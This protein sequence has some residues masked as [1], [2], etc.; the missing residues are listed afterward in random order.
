MTSTTMTNGTLLGILIGLAAVAIVIGA[1]IATR[2][3]ARERSIELR[4]QFGPEY[5]QAVEDY[6]SQT[7]AEREL[8]ARAR[9]VG[10][11]KLAELTVAARERYSVR[12]SR[13][14]EQFV[15]DPLAAV[16]AASSLIDDVMRARGYPLEDFD[17]R[18]ADLSVDHSSVTQ[19]YRAARALSAALASDRGN[20]E[21]LRQAF[22]HYRALFS[23]LVIEAAPPA[24]RSHREAHAH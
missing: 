20:T 7:R 21:D 1:A 23:D 10:H 4:R 19:H 24:S 5:D 17:Q 18:L 13:I 2:R 3:R 12:W 9:R 16:A 6:G 14:Q 22:V 15:D 11:L 8:A